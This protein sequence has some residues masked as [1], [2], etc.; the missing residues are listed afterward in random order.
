MVSGTQMT[1]DQWMPEVFQRQT[2]GALDHH[3]RIS[4][5]VENAEGWTETGVPSF[6]RYFAY[7]GKRGNKIDPNG[8]SMKMLRECYQATEDLISLP[9]SLKWM[10]L[11]M[12]SNG[13]LLTQSTLESHKAVKECSLLDIIED[14]VNEK[15]YLSENFVKRMSR[16][17]DKKFYVVGR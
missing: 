2:V 17:I 16:I 15:Y 9:F 5:S 7:L 14:S 8:S 10:N 3:A 1:L 12:T 4:P 13:S 11:G 6:E